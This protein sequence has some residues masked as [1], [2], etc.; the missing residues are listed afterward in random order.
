MGSKLSKNSSPT[1]SSEPIAVSAPVTLN[2]YDLTPFNKYTYWFGIGIFHSGIEVYGLEYGFGAHDFPTSGVF[3]VEPKRCPGFCYRRSI[4]LGT[5]TMLPFEFRELIET[6]AGEYHGDTYHLILKNCNHFT[7]EVSL[8]LTG[9]SIPRWVNRL[10]H[11]S[12]ICSCLLPKNLRI[13]AVEENPESHVLLD[14]AS[15]SYGIISP[16]ESNVSDGADGENFVLSP[17]PASEVTF[18]KEKEPVDE[19]TSQA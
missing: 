5:T 1:S 4:T 12:A 2:V 3:E 13:A 19:K 8:R 7:D 11:I 9:K 18:I 6:I 14:D 17:S 16:L 15:G 10:A